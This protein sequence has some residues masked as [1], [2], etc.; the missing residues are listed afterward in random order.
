MTRFKLDEMLARLECE[1]LAQ[2]LIDSQGNQSKA[3]RLV[4]LR[5]STFNHRLKVRGL[6]GK[7]ERELRRV[8]GKL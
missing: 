1:H 2:A 4:G 3:C 5:R 7:S 6:R 8:A